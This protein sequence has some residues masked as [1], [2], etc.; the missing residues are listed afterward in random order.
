MLTNSEVRHT[1][2]YMAQSQIE[3]E[4]TRALNSLRCNVRDP[5]EQ[6]GTVNLMLMACENYLDKGIESQHALKALIDIWKQLKIREI[7]TG[8]VSTFQAVIE[9]LHEKVRQDFNNR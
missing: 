6:V 7:T 1:L 2:R 9:R 4:A 8:S 3:V 5:I